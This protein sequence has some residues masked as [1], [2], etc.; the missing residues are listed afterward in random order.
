M[1]SCLSIVP[2]ARELCLNAYPDLGIDDGRVPSRIAN[3]LVRD[4]A[5]V[6]GVAQNAIQVA[7]TKWAAPHCIGPAPQTTVQQATPSIF[8]IS[9]SDFRSRRQSGVDFEALVGLFGL[10]LSLEAVCLRQRDGT[11]EPGVH[12]LGQGAEDRAAFHPARQAGSKRLH[13]RFNRTYRDVVLTRTYSIR[14]TR[15][16]RSRPSGSRVTTKSGRTTR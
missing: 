16:A 10:P 8:G 5:N 14:S 9:D 7:S 11:N 2:I 12:R 4:L 3:V 15:C 13:E 1:A 6:D